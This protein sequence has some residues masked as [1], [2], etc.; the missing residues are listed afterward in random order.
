[1]IGWQDFENTVE[2]LQT[3]FEGLCRLFF[4]QYYAGSPDVILNQSANNPGLETEPIA[5]GENR[6]GFQ[7]KYF[8]N[9][10]LYKDIL[11][12]AKKVVKYYSGKID[13]I[14]LFC[15]KDITIT[16]KTYQETV[17]LLRDNQI[18]IE[19]C[20]NH[21][22]LD[23]I[24]TNPQY[25]TIKALYFGELTFS[26]E[27]FARR[28][29]QSLKEL[30]PRYVSGFHVDVQEQQYYFEALYRSNI[31]RDVLLG[32]IKQAKEN[33]EKLIGYGFQRLRNS[34]KEIIE[35][36]VIPERNEYEKIFDWLGLFKEVKIEIT[37][38]KEQKEKIIEEFYDK[39]QTLNQE[40]EKRTRNEIYSLRRLLG[41][42]EQFNFNNYG[43]DKCL[44]NNF[45]LLEGDAGKGKSHLLGY[46]AETHKKSKLYRSVLLM[47]HKFVLQDSPQN[48]IMSLLGKPG[49]LFESFLDSCEGYG[50]LN[51]IITVIMI[52]AINECQ[53]SS[54]WRAYI[55]QIIQLVQSYRYVKIVC[56]IRSTYKEHFFE[57]DLIEDIN[58]GNIP[59][60][61]VVGFENVLTEAI[62]IFFSYY[63]IP[64]TTSDYFKE[65]FKDPLFLRT[66][67]EVYHSLKEDEGSQGIYDLYYRYIEKEEKRVKTLK[68]IIDDFN[69]GNCITEIIGKYFYEQ[70]TNNIPYIE[71]IKELNVFS[72]SAKIVIDEFLKAKV[73]ISYYGENRSLKVYLN[74]ERF[75]DFIAAKHIINGT[76][77][78]TEL[79]QFINTNFFKLNKYGML[80]NYWDIA[81][82]AALSVLA[83]EKYN[84]EII[85]QVEI[86]KS[87][88]IKNYEKE[89]IVKEYLQAFRYRNDKH[90]NKE[91][92]FAT[93]VPYVIGT[94]LVQSHLELLLSM[95]GRNCGLNAETLTEWLMGLSLTDRDYIWTEY[96]NT[97][98]KE[99]AQIYYCIN[100]FLNQDL[101]NVEVAL[102]LRY[103]QALGWFLTSSN[104]TLR[105]KASKALI[106]LLV[107]NFTVISD[108]FNI[109]ID[110]NDPYV[111]SR[112]MGCFYGAILLSNL[113]QLDKE[114]YKK[115]CQKIYN[116]IF[117]CKIVYPDILLRDYALN[118]LEYATSNGV[119]L[120]FFIEKCRPPYKSYEIPNISV[121]ELKQMY[122]I[123]GEDWSGLKAIER[124][125]APEYGIKDFCSGYGDFGRYTFQSALRGFENV[126]LEKIFRYAYY[127]IIK[128]LG[129][130]NDLFSYNDKMVGYGRGRESSTERIGKKYQWITM[131]H[132]LALVS[133][134]H[135]CRENFNGEG[136]TSYK[137][138]WRPYIR[139]FDPTLVK[140]NCSADYEFGVKLC[141]AEYNEWDISNPLWAKTFRGEQKHEELV[142]I[143][144]DN[145]DVWCGLYVSIQDDSSK[146]WRKS[147]Q[148]FWRS[149]MGCLIKNSEKNNF[150]EKLQDKNFYG[151]WFDAVENRQHYNIFLREYAWAPAYRDEIEIG[152]IPAEIETEKRV[153]KEGVIDN[154]EAP[155]TVDLLKNYLNDETGRWESIKEVIGHIIP[156]YD[157]YTWEEE[158]DYSKEEV[159]S[160]VLPVKYIIDKLQLSQIKDGVWEKDGEIACV[161]FGCVKNS[162]LGKSLYIKKK[163]LAELLGDDL[164]IVWIGIGEKQHLLEAWER[165]NQV[166]S[167]LSSLIYY[168]NDG[169][170][171]E[172]NHINSK[173]IDEK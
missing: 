22:L 57:Q 156:C 119:A 69:Y 98:Y 37:T 135:K 144:D 14:I 2:N 82:F 170:L 45:L 103:A 155:L 20:C 129:Y 128:N 121:D 68:K 100:F 73:L 112:L 173:P 84:V 148:S 114:E 111:I 168:N 165:G 92:Y 46:I 18:Q 62:P 147:R 43:W 26:E 162:N 10:I 150:I 65:E 30:E 42:I 94:D 27:W 124:S 116:E 70:K 131:Y 3:E 146:D 118:I 1:M 159:V 59:I 54:I 166:W 142:E 97:Q 6:I 134:S 24:N 109:F 64:I 161:D 89:N 53:D 49:V 136:V 17:T 107:N 137:G 36:L 151:R 104:R 44:K 93:V 38:I 31:V 140:T 126:D 34:I 9:N 72:A 41:I 7:A 63:G 12:S 154:E 139:D 115:F 52:D 15:N 13:K 95:V 75:S 153:V 56:S 25:R 80:E 60:V 83:Y 172:I 125:M 28:L 99:G 35:S 164:S 110:V 122:D 157:F 85:D 79:I 171:V 47:G 21:N 169:E 88:E 149:S 96:I 86:L 105:D 8:S 81:R 138:T 74:Y 133:D 39:E 160:L 102:R 163:F 158:C 77:T 87:D 108:L 61:R 55:N 91:K 51:G 113:K 132:I 66:Y 16:A 123:H 141:R 50:E 127:Y 78:I 19:T 67:C 4:K 58:T 90:I 48:Q 32:I 76:N 145:G 106:K 40:E 11:D 71:L 33:L 120:E 101:N 29:T 143:T 152:F 167:E 5:V 23:P 117:G 130:D